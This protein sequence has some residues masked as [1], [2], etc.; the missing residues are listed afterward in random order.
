M[1]PVGRDT[2]LKAQNRNARLVYCGRIPKIV[3]TKGAQMLIIRG[4]Q[5]IFIAIIASAAAFASACSA[6]SEKS[7]NREYVKASA[8]VV[9]AE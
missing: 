8:N 6:S 2:M 5:K 7:A 4:M 9:K 1:F 3:F